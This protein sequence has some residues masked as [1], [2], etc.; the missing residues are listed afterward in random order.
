[1]AECSS[2]AVLEVDFKAYSVPQQQYNNIAV[3]NVSKVCRSISSRCKMKFIGEVLRN[4]F[5]NYLKGQTK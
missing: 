4:R 1:M 5:I 2:H 3:F